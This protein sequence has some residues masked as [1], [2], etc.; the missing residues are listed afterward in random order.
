MMKRFET[1]YVY[2]IRSANGYWYLVQQSGDKSW[3]AMVFGNLGIHRDDVFRHGNGKS[4]LENLRPT[5][6][7]KWVN[8]PSENALVR[9][10]Q[11]NVLKY[12][13]FEE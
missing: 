4:L 8:V 2:I 9:K 13:R 12:G 6:L 5:D 3:E 1:N 7:R 11:F 10:A